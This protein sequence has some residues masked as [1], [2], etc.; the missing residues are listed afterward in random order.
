M[1][2]VNVTEFRNHLPEYLGQ[3]KKGEDIF[4]TSRGRI[5]AR[6][7][8]VTDE[9]AA[10]REALLLLRGKC[11]IGDVVSPLDEKWEA[12]DAGP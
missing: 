1:I 9:R 5:V 6:V 10:A 8:P 7:M 4:L 12:G 2:E 11:R 3:V